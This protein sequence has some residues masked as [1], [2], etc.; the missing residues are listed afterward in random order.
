MNEAWQAFCNRTGIADPCPTKKAMSQT[1]YRDVSGI[2]ARKKEERREISRRS[3][4]EKIAM[5]E[6]MRERLA[7]LKRIRDERRANRKSAAPSLSKKGT[8]NSS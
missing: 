2:L 1:I 7:P 3:F 5:V 6:V 8:P 4:C